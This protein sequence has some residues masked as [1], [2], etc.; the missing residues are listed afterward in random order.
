MVFLR[1]FLVAM[2]T[3]YVTIVNVSCLAIIIISSDGISLSLS[4]T[5]WFYNYIKGQGF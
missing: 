1:G 2:L 4:A 5:E 3:Y